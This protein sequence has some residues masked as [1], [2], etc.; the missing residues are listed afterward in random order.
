MV[1][2]DSSSYSNNPG[3]LFG[4]DGRDGEAGGGLGLSDPPDHTRLRRML[5]PEFTTRRLAVLTPRIERTV[6]RQLDAME[7][8]ARTDRVVDLVEHLARPVPTQTILGLLGLTADEDRELERL[9]AT[10]FDT[11]G[12]IQAVFGAVNADVDALTPLV[13]HHRAHPGTGLLGR[14]ISRHGGELSDRELAGLV[15]GLLTGGLETTAAT[16]AMGTLVLLERPGGIALFPT[17]REAVEHNIEELLRFLT[18]V[19]V[20][21]P[22]IARRDVL[23]GPHRVREGDI[24]IVSLVAANRD[25]RWAGAGADPNDY[26]PARETPSSHLAFGHGIHRCIGAELAKLELRITLPALARRFPQMRVATGSDAP[27]FRSMS[28]VHGL[29][30]LPVRLSPE[31][32]AVQVSVDT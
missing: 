2:A 20:G 24:V 11:A 18:V 1:L 26:A 31:E 19:Q 8:A 29:D 7:D 27:M 15:D 5:T 13:R 32:G 28:L 16:I 23:L 6:A 22:R 4:I 14:L 12:G 21:F 3:A 10:R 25:Q 9:C 30:T 17:S